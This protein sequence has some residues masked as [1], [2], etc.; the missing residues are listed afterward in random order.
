LDTVGRY[1]P[2]IKEA[3]LALATAGRK[4]GLIVNE[5]NTKHMAAEK[6]RTPNM[7]S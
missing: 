6:S 1:F 3:F 5:N 7:P 2:V 4:M